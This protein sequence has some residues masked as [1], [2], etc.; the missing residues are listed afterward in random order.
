MNIVCP[1]TASGSVLTG[2]RRTFIDVLVAVLSLPSWLASALIL[3]MLITREQTNIMLL[4]NKCYK[5]ETFRCNIKNNIFILWNLFY[6]NI[7]IWKHKT[8]WSLSQECA[9]MFRYIYKLLITHQISTGH[10]MGTDI[11]GTFVNVS[12]AVVTREARGAWAL[13]RS[14][15]IHAATTIQAGPTTALVYVLFASC[16]WT[17]KHIIEK[18]MNSNHTE[19]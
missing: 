19:N 13:M 10:S 7:Q 15:T 18:G 11:E 4:S 1:V 2:V 3:T 8:H 16:S 17:I 14:N 6:Y 12:L 5:S 9:W